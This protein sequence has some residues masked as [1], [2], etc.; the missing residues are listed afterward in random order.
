MLA[1]IQFF[2]TGASSQVVV[3]NFLEHEQAINMFTLLV[4]ICI[5]PTRK[6]QFSDALSFQLSDLVQK[7]LG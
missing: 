2:F 3:S 1:S 4:L 7:Y 5:F 6:T